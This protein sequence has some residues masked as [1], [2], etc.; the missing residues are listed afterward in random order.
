MRKIGVLAA[1]AA[2]CF[3]G[4]A[5]VANA[6]NVYQLTRAAVSPTKA[7]TATNPRPIRLNF[8]FQTTTDDGNRP[9]PG[10]DYI[11]GFGPGVKQNRAF[12]RRCTNAQAGFNSGR[13]ANCP[14]ASLIGSGRVANQAGLAADP[15]QKIPCN[16]RLRLYNGDGRFAATGPNDGKRVRAD[17]WLVLN[18]APND[19]E[20]SRCPLVVGPAAIPAQFVRYLG[21][22]GLSFHVPR[23]PFQQPQTG[24]ENA[25][26]ETTAS[27]F[28]T[29]RRRERVRGRTVTRT[30]GF[31]E[32]TRCPAGGHP[33]NLR[34]ADS[35]GAVKTAPSRRA[36][37]RR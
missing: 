18:G 37:C 3:G 13:T 12:F 32:T 33:I 34:I 15:T 16:L 8:G 20:I 24:V 6:A 10:A 29:V 30:R 25:L 11:I 22:T 28:K 5:A 2:A 19:P 35:T 23:V 7:G 9:A 21:G 14:A 1:A 26:V 36:P 4:Y 17:V 31:L 27:I